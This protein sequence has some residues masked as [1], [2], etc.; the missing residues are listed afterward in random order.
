MTLINGSG[1]TVRT[2][3]LRVQDTLIHTHAH[4]QSREILTAGALQRSGELGWT[5][6]PQGDPGCL[7][8]HKGLRE[9]L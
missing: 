6:I 8:L 3:I 4:T 1:G 7:F 9:L 2:A 5:T